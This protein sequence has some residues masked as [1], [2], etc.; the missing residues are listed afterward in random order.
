MGAAGWA[1]LHTRPPE[2]SRS[3]YSGPQGVSPI[4]SPCGLKDK[5]S[6]KAA[7]LECL[8]LWKWQAEGTFHGHGWGL[9]ASACQGAASGSNRRSHDLLQLSPL[10]A[11]CLLIFQNATGKRVP[12]RNFTGYLPPHPNSCQN[13][14]LSP[15]FSSVQS[16]SRVRLFA[17]P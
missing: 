2:S 8:P 9:G 14:P 4:H 11:R 10:P 15:Q 17:T 1:G 16:L 6:L 7:Q 13:L 12:L 5:Y 3:L